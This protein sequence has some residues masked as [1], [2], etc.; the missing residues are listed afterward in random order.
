MPEILHVDELAAL[1]G[2]ELGVSAWFLIDQQCIDA[3]A[4][5][6]GDDQWIHT[7]PVRAADS[8]FGTTVAHGL[9]TLSVIPHLAAQVFQI[10][11]V[12]SRINYGYDR[13]RFPQPVHVGAMVRDQIVLD[14]V[15]AAPTG[16][17]L[18]LTHTVEVEGHD[19]PACV[20]TAL[21]QLVEEKR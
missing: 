20:A 19:R 7:D 8:I 11:G 17:R 9:L 6:T 12:L 10:E 18:T 15:T 21:V 1:V 2:E 5:V 13:I 4:A 3:F 14:A 16:P